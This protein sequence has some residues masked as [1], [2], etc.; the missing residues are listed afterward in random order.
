MQVDWFTE[1]LDFNSFDPAALTGPDSSLNNLTQVDTP[2]SGTILPELN[3]NDELLIPFPEENI[4]IPADMPSPEQ[5]VPE[6]QASSPYSTGS[7]GFST[8]SSPY[9]NYSDNS[10]ESTVSLV[11]LLSPDATQSKA[12][13]TQSL[14]TPKRPT[15]YSKQA[16]KQQQLTPKPKVKTPAQRQRKRVQ[17]KDAATRYRIKKRSEQDLLFEEVEKNEKENKNLKDQIASISK[18]IEYLKN[19]MV[20][21]YKNKQKQQQPNQLQTAA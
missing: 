7:E 17:N 19:L 16:S 11:D 14:S 12:Q 10:S 21:V 8:P 18:E 2:S 3:L 6:Y 4:T 1:K 20:E 5:K 9:S 13:K 15:P